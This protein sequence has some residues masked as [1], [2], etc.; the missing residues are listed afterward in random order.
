MSKRTT[1]GRLEIQVCLCFVF[2]TVRIF[3]KQKGLQIKKRYEKRN[4]EEIES[5]I[6]FCYEIDLYDF[7]VCYVNICNCP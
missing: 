7:D 3:K 1:Y 5:F 4:E 6:W 2:F